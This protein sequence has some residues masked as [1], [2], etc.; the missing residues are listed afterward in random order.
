VKSEFNNHSFGFIGANTNDWIKRKNKHGELVRKNIL[1]PEYNT[2]RYN[3][4]KR[5]IV[6]FISENDFVHVQN[7]EKSAYLL[8]RNSQLEKNP[9]LEQDITL[10]FSD[11]FDML[12]ENS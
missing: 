3:R 8:L 9:N 1:E 10:Y 12:M 5:I 11:N 4:Y 7:I 2:K 6:T